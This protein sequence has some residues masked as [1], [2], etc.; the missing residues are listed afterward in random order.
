MKMKT[1]VR[2]LLLIGVVGFVVGGSVFLHEW[3]KPKRSIVREKAAYV[4]TL[5]DVAN[6]FIAGL[7]TANQKYLN[8]VIELSAEVSSI[9]QDAHDNV[10]FIF[11][12]EGMEVQVTFLAEFNE[13]AAKV[14]AGEQVRLKG[15]YTGYTEDDIFGLQVKLNN[16]YIL[17]DN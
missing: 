2:N 5:A 12:S 13:D 15:N 10:N 3:F 16:G 4:V 1:V 17:T 8:K 7:A 14:N 11:S 6:D 9:E